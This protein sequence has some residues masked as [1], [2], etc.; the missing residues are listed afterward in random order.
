MQLSVKI[1]EPRKL[2]IEEITQK[3]NA[4]SSELC[5]SKIIER[6]TPLERKKISVII[7][8]IKYNANRIKNMV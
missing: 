2:I 4:L 7:N 3:V 8:E 6:C 5:V 1:T